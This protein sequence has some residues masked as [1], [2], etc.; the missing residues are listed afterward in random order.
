MIKAALVGNPNSGKTTI[1]NQLSAS[2][3]RIGNWA[4]VTVDRKEAQLH[5][6]YDCKS[7]TIMISDLPGTYSMNSYTLDED[8]TVKYLKSRHIDV[9]VNVIDILSFERSL[10]FTLQLLEHNIPMVV[11]INKMDIA[12]KKKINIDP[13]LLSSMINVPVI[14]T[15]ANKKIGLQDLVDAIITQKYQCQVVCTREE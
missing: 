1:F 4:G 8:V 3:E 13:T 6:H 2:S 12:K 11:V 5:C 9:I 7:E 15:Q 10:E 14:C